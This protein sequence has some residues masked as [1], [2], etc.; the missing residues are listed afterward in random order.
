MFEGRTSPRSSSRRRTEGRDGLPRAIEPRDSIKRRARIVIVYP[1][2]APRILSKALQ[3]MRRS[4]GDTAAHRR[5]GLSHSRNGN[6][7]ALAAVKAALVSNHIRKT[8]FAA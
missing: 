6:S 8:H 5:R 2:V 3:V 1:P 4:K 7:I